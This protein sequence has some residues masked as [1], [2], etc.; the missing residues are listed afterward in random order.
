MAVIPLKNRLADAGISV[1]RMAKAIGYAQ[2]TVCVA[3]NTGKLPQRRD[4]AGEV[5]SFLD[6]EG[7][8]KEGIWE[9][10]ATP[11]QKDRPKPGLQTDDEIN[12]EPEML[13]HDALRHFKLFRNPFF[14]EVRAA[15]DVFISQEMRFILT[16]MRDT[17]R[18][19]GILAV[20]GDSGAG[21]SVLRRLMTSELNRDGEVAIIMPRIFDKTRVTA[22]GL[23][24]AIIADTSDEDPRRSLEAKA[25]QVERILRASA[26]GGR[27]NVLVIEE[28]HDL[29]IP[30]L[31][32][33][34]RFWEMED[35]GFGSLL[36][37]IL[38]G[39]SELGEKLDERRHYEAR[40]F[41]RRCLV[42]ELTPLANDIEA[43][44]THKFQRA[45][46]DVGRVLADGAVQAMQRRLS[47]LDRRTGKNVSVA[48]PL[49]VHNLLVKSMNAAV[50][51]GEQL[52]TPEIILE[53]S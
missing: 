29:T 39:Q 48:Y 13:S 46:G 21:K 30:V 25:R 45:G 40:E 10:A 24:D 32:Y 18:N 15:D 38:V 14:E 4:F 27:R 6:R 22:G 52:V 3:V 34:K 1:K 11:T 33:L 49:A 20:I 9:G 28:A 7:V 47:R 43:Y 36:G 19:Q 37:I 51:L 53:V 17:A 16:A 8:S 41:I 50:E 31:K 5:E 23:C 42:V 26:Q 12:L 44:L 35:G 2:S